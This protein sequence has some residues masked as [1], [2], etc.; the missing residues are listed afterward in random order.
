MD[1]VVNS[2]CVFVMNKGVPNN[3]VVVVTLF[4][5]ILHE[6]DTYNKIES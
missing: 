5:N 2:L 4:S 1:I 3:L 6:K